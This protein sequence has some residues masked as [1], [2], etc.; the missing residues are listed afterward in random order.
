M[1]E[2]MY[3]HVQYSTEQSYLIYLAYINSQYIYINSWYISE[4]SPKSIVYLP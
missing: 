4:F 3:V 2:S 1:L